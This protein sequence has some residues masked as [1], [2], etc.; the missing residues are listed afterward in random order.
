M[1]GAIE[2]APWLGTLAAFAEDP[3]SVPGT[4]MV[5]YNYL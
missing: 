3:D 2:K 1:D 4:G 5:A